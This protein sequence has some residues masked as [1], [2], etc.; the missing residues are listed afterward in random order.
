[1]QHFNFHHQVQNKES[2][3]FEQHLE[4]LE[5]HIRITF[6][7]LFS[8]PYLLG[9]CCTSFKFNFSFCESY[10]LDKKREKSFLSV[11]WLALGQIWTTKKEAD[12]L[13][14]C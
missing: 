10:G 13:T 3:R 7:K 6:F 11:I 1:M 14:Q 5:Q 8:L 9:H 2:Q 12:S 4:L